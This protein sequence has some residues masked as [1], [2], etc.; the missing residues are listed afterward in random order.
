MKPR[1][2]SIKQAFHNAIGSKTVTLDGIRLHVGAEYLPR[3]VANT[4]KRGTYEFAERQLVKAYLDASDSV[5]EIGTGVGAVALLTA[6]IVGEGSVTC[7][8]ANPNLQTV[9]AANRELNGL[10]PELVNF[11]VTPDGSDIEFCVMDN[12]LSSSVYDRGGKPVTLK[13]KRFADI[14]ADKQ[15][16]TLIMDVEGLE[17]QLLTGD[18]PGVRKII[19]E[20]HPKIVGGEKTDEMMRGLQAVGF[21]QAAVLQDNVV[22]LRQA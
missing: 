9:I 6:K 7:Y 15:P 16:T 8:E 20:T 4:I 18:L 10:H 19:V 12:I 3:D 1:F 22:L 21:R 2:R 17:T 14:L 11:P 13:S 5:V